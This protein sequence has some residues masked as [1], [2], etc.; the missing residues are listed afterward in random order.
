[1][2]VPLVIFFTVFCCLFFSKRNVSSCFLKTSVILI[3]KGEEKIARTEN[4]K[5][6]KEQ[7]RMNNLDSPF[8]IPIPTPYCVRTI[9]GHLPPPK[10]FS[11]RI[12]AEYCRRF[13][14]NLPHAFQNYSNVI[15]LIF[16]CKEPEF[17]WNVCGILL[18]F[19]W[20]FLEFG[21]YFDGIS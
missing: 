1:M 17:L 9:A 12:L 18:E 13:C 14:P 15:P 20:Y 16:L 3:F 5:P 7:P 4:E 10:T 11:T 21:W 6:K 8:P 2:L 19:L